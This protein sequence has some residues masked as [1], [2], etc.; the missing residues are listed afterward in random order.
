MRHLNRGRKLG[1][2][3]SHY[4][5]L[6]RNMLTSL[7]R[8]GQIITTISKAKECAPLA[9]KVISI[10]KRAEE[11]IKK[12]QKK[13]TSA[14]RGEVTP[15]IQVQIDKQAKAIRVASFRRALIKVQGKE[16]V[17][18][19]FYKIAPLYADRQGGYTK[20]LK[21]NKH[22]IG[23]NGPLAVLK[24]VIPLPQETDKDESKGKDS[25]KEKSK[26]EKS[27]KEKSKKD[28]KRREKEL[29][30]KESEKK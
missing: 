12:M 17:R 21:I 5:A 10:A 19:L 7:F 28:K 13:I 11:K 8:H 3:R 15:E 20:V 6:F 27:K 26:K 30:K 24:L 23:D 16:I 4:R 14:A 29:A 18:K 2:N 1:R 25:K 22:R 9:D